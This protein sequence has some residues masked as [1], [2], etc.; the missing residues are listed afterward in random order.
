[1]HTR[2]NCIIAQQDYVAQCLLQAFQ[3][4]LQVRGKGKEA[5]VPCGSVS[6]SDRSL[7]CSL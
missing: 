6:N 1:M 5:I 3:E 4:E 2:L 7:P